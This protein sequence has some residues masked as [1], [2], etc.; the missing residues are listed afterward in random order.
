MTAVWGAMLAVLGQL[1]G[2]AKVGELDVA[3]G[4]QQQVLGLE[5]PAGTMRGLRTKAQR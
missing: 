3:R 4:V 5:V 2:E 1:A